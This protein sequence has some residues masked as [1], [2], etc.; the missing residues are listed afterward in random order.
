MSALVRFAIVRRPFS[1][2]PYATFRLHNFS[3]ALP[4]GN[5]FELFESGAIAAYGVDAYPGVDR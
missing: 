1:L 2:R 3:D 4:S 5:V